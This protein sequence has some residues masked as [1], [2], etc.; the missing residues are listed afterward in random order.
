[1]DVR[2]ATDVDAAEIAAL[3]T[4]L[5]Y[6]AQPLEIRRRLALLEE[7]DAVLLTVGGMVAL[8]RIPLLAEGGAVA[9]I[10]ALV[11]A[12]DRRGAGIGRELLAAAEQVARRWGC[13]LVEVS[14]GRRQERE[15]A[16]RFYRAAGFEDTATRSTRYWK[17]LALA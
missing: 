15:S 3:L 13:D 11:V 1:M 6:P 16:H 4:A 14:S 5:G 17:R 2:P 10:T 9:R 7:S 8:H 12:P